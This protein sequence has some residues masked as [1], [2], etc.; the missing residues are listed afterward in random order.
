[1][2]LKQIPALLTFQFQG[3]VI[4]KRGCQSIRNRADIR[5]RNFESVADLGKE[6]TLSLA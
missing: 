6:S 4:T 1:L 5:G 3:S 2:L